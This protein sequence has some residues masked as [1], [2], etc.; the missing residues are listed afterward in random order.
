MQQTACNQDGVSYLQPHKNI[1]YNEWQR[2]PRNRHYTCDVNITK[3]LAKDYDS[4][5]TTWRD[6]NRTGYTCSKEQQKRHRH[7]TL[8][9]T[10][11]QHTILNTHR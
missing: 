8:H 11:H 3:A 9:S 5:C 1:R 7:S 4:P 2:R 6:V 10:R